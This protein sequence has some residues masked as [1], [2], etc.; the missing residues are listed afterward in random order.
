MSDTE[1]IAQY[2]RDKLDLAR[3]DPQEELSYASLPLCI[4]DT[5]FSIGA[6]YASTELAVKR[7]CEYEHIPRLAESCNEA[8]EQYSVQAILAL[9][10]RLGVRVIAEQVFHNRQRT[11]TRSGILKSEAV[12]RFC[13]V[14]HEFSVNTLQDAHK[15][16]ENELFETRIK[17][18]P[19]HNSGISTRYLYILLD[20]QDY[21]KPDRMVMRFIE[22]ATGKHYSVE[23]CQHV[24][25]QVCQLLVPEYP[26]LTPSRLDHLIWAFQRNVQ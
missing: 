23:E 11:S 25:M 21:V 24:L 9:Y 6:R 2:C 15:I 22:S 16:I 4:I 14:L 10:A 1:I 3:P 20:S 18:I 19:G 17:T 7:F 12:L 5:V 26:R 13:Q 8:E